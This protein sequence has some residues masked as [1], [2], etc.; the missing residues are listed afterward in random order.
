L[1]F[2]SKTHGTKGVLEFELASIND[3]TVI[4][5]A[6]APGYEDVAWMPKDRMPKKTSGR[7][8]F[9][10][11]REAAEGTSRFFDE[12]GYQDSLIVEP[13]LIPIDSSLSYSISDVSPPRFGDFYYFR[14]TFKNGGIA[15]SSPAYVG[16]FR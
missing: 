12:E 2:L 7:K 15:Y 6:L 3:D 9:I 5:V 16:D 8:V 10:P 14:V 11:I 13:A 1:D 4:E